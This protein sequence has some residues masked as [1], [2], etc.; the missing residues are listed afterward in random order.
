MTEGI[1]DIAEIAR[2]RRDRKPKPHHDATDTTNSKTDLVI[3]KFGNW[4]IDQHKRAK[5][6]ELIAS[7]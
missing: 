6:Q 3:E 4:V 7:C 1:A 2:H 5:S